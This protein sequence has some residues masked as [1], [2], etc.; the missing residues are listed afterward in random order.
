MYEVK[1]MT[2]GKTEVV[3]REFGSLNEAEK[4]ATKVFDLICG[5]GDSIAVTGP[6][7]AFTLE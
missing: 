2:E 5:P 1:V 3:N 4:W 7:G 6:D